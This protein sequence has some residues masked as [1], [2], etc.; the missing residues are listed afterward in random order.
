MAARLRCQTGGWIDLH[1]SYQVSIR[2]RNNVYHTCN[3]GIS[4]TKYQLSLIYPPAGHLMAHC[5]FY[6][7]GREQNSRKG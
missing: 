6:E 1:F 3:A 4:S 7:L 5:F 2:S